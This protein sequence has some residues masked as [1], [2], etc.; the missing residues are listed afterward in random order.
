ME[1]MIMQKLDD[2]FNR[3]S[4]QLDVKLEDIHKTIKLHSVDIMELRG[5]SFAAECISSYNAEEFTGLFTKEERE[6]IR[7]EI[8]AACGVEENEE[9]E[10]NE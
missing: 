6:A 8:R 4:N 2:L 10:E 3:L 5:K 1:Q 9:N 7:K